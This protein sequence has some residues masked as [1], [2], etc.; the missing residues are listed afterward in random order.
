MVLTFILGNGFDQ[1]I[2]MSTSYRDF[3]QWY[4]NPASD[5]SEDVASMKK[6]INN[7]IRGEDNTWADFEMALGQYTN[8]FSNKAQ[9]IE[10]FQHARSALIRY[11]ASQYE[12]I[13]TENKDFLKSATY[14]LI[15]L[16]QNISEELS[17]AQRQLFWVGK[18]TN[19]IFNCISFN[20]TPILRD[21]TQN[22]K[23]NAGGISNRDGWYGT[24][25][26]G[27]MIN[28]HGLL[29]DFPILGVDNASQIAN[30]S[31]R[32]DPD[33]LQLMVKGEIDKKLGRKW[34]S[35]AQEIIRN[36]DKIY[37]YGA[38]L[39]ATDEFWWRELALWLEEDP[40]NHQF[41]LYCH[42]K[43][44]S[45]KMNAER[46][47]I[48][49]SISKHFTRGDYSANIVIDDKEKTMTVKFAYMSAKVE[50]KTFVTANPSAV[51]AISLSIER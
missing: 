42:P 40:D 46:D 15:E 32:D 10:V 34:R 1:A 33:I 47:R 51:P 16:S 14:R 41:A 11:L 26:L 17:E 22:M 9:F 48:V 20:Y 45:R 50:I 8:K 37:V 24:Y 39:G 36:S 28:V 43:T 31:F 25:K 19:T 49:R 44:D 21:G 5:D 38:S 7:Y 13:K 12:S 3:Y 23:D 30:E 18:E 27:K 35:E 4:K 2:G 6:E 29:D